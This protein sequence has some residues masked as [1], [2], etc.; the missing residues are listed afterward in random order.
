[1]CFIFNEVRDHVEVVGVDEG[2]KWILKKKEERMW[3]GLIW[4]RIRGTDL[5]WLHTQR[6]RSYDVRTIHVASSTLGRRLTTDF[7]S[8]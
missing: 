5:G 2:I 8:D 3:T 6:H 1:M 4:L 7:R